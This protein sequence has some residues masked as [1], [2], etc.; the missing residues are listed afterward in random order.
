M[1]NIKCC[2]SACFNQIGDLDEKTGKPIIF[3]KFPPLMKYKDDE[4]TKLS[5]ERRRAWKIALKIIDRD[6]ISESYICSNHFKAGAPTENLRDKNNPDWVPS[7]NLK[8]GYKTSAPER[9]KSPVAGTASTHFE[10]IPQATVK[11]ENDEVEMGD[12]QYEDDTLADQTQIC[13]LC[14]EQFSAAE[15][16]PLY[17]REWN[18]TNLVDSIE[19]VLSVKVRL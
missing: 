15:L 13:R 19:S 9:E 18:H 11:I 8:F 6:V 2:V 5:A 10:N 14:S 4:L 12:Y 3:F 1:A 7:L 16:F 17:D